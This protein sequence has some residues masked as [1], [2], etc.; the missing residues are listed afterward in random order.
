MRQ[1]RVSN[2]F[3]PFGSSPKIGLFG[4]MFENGGNSWNDWNCLFARNFWN[5]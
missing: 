5:Y 1:L 3:F 4:G 2:Y